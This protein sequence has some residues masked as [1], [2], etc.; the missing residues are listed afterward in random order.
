MKK[1]I[2][3]FVTALLCFSITACGNSNKDSNKNSGKDDYNEIQKELEEIGFKIFLEDNKTVLIDYNKAPSIS[4]T[5]NKNKLKTIY[6]DYDSDDLS[7][8]GIVYSDDGKSDSISQDAKAFYNGFM[9][10]FTYTKDEMKD[11][12]YWYYKENKSDKKSN[13]EKENKSNT[14]E[15]IEDLEN[16]Y[17]EIVEDAELK[18]IQM[19]SYFKIDN[20]E[21][22]DDLLGAEFNFAIKSEVL[23]KITLTYTYS[24][25]IMYSFVYGLTSNSLIGVE[26][27]APTEYEETVVW[28]M[29]YNIE[30]SP[31]FLTD[32]DKANITS[33]LKADTGKYVASDKYYISVDKTGNRTIYKLANQSGLYN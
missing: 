12:A 15:K 21:P 5:Y 1:I 7:V 25:D 19:D 16:D 32:Q 17:Y 9:S 30:D 11:F 3:L 18:S 28:A 31:A 6:F 8:S 14:Y 33:A 24:N 29:M 22:I 23:D 2:K 26:V 27:N 10:K 20:I 13:Q 4:Y